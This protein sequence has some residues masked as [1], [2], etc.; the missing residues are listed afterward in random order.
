[1]TLNI[2]SEYYHHLLNPHAVTDRMVLFQCGTQTIFFIH[3]TK[4]DGEHKLQKCQKSYLKVNYSDLLCVC[5][6]V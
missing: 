2:I 4:V 3:T 5:V 6:C 1:M